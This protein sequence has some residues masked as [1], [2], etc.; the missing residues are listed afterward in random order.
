MNNDTITTARFA[1]S[2]VQISDTAI[3]WFPDMDRPTAVMCV[4][5]VADNPEWLAFVDTSTIGGRSPSY[6]LSYA[7]DGVL[8]PGKWMFRVKAP[9]PITNVNMNG[10]PVALPPPPPPSPRTKTLI[11]V[12]NPLL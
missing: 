4:G 1:G 7:D 3:A 6:E 9:Q 11:G 10:K 8:G 2:P 5:I 12:T